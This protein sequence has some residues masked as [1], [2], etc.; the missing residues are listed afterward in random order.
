[1]ENFNTLLKE[2]FHTYQVY[3]NCT[4]VLNGAGKLSLCKWP[5][6]AQSSLIYINMLEEQTEASELEMARQMMYNDYKVAIIEPIR[7]IYQATRDRFKEVLE[8]DPA[9]SAEA[10]NKPIIYKNNLI[11]AIN[12]MFSAL[13]AVTGVDY[14]EVKKYGN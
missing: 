2:A 13:N 6:V 1:M 3:L 14:P 8:A 11:D 9:I 10:S 5:D 4:G 7:A 12:K